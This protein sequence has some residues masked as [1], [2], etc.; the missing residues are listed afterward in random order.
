MVRS[1][2]PIWGLLLISLTG[3][4]SASV[5]TDDA[6]APGE[7]AST[8]RDARAGTDALG[9]G[10]AL[11]ADVSA[12]DGAEPSDAGLA[13]LGV[14]PD[15]D[16]GVGDAGVVTTPITLPYNGNLM[17]PQVLRFST[18]VNTAILVR[19]V[20]GTA[21]PGTLTVRSAAGP[22]IESFSFFED[23][24]GDQRY[25]PIYLQAGGDYLVEVD[26]PPDRDRSFL[27][28]IEPITTLLPFTLGTNQEA[29][30]NGT[31]GTL[32]FT[33]TA[34]QGD[35]LR[36]SNARV[37]S[38]FNGRFYYQDLRFA[39]N[40]AQQTVRRSGLQLV[41]LRK[42]GG[43]NCPPDPDFGLR[44]WRA[45]PITL[46]VSSPPASVSTTAFRPTPL[47]FTFQAPVGT[48]VTGKVTGTGYAYFFTTWFQD[49]FQDPTSELFY[50]N[51]GPWVITDRKSVV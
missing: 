6:A 4:P 40:T 50:G 28:A 15:P 39:E 16:G 11:A 17:G 31:T 2:A 24:V 12:M 43:A 7:D 25:V 26:A 29:T 35:I 21:M 37:C 10:D 38:Q 5:S 22:L 45:S 13:D 44:I 1:T 48:I 23:A 49:G 51:F 36:L 41:G 46:G 34:T 42:V 20:S 14:L 9:G 47:S 33:F 18:A 19:A 27:V 32:G 8:A 30:V 3:C